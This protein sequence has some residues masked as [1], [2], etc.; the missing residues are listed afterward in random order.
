MKISVRVLLMGIVAV[1][2]T[3]MS[4]VGIQGA[5]GMQA[6]R[7]ALGRIY[8][9][10]FLPT[11]YISQADAALVTWNREMLKY[12]TASPGEMHQVQVDSVAR[13]REIIHDKLERLSALSN[14]DSEEE[15][16][17]KAL[18]QELV[19]LSASWDQVVRLRE[20]GQDARAKAFLWTTITP[21]IDLMSSEVTRFVA[22]QEKQLRQV[23]AQAT[24]IFRGTLVR[25]LLVVVAAIFLSLV[26]NLSLSMRM[27]ES[28][29]RL[30][31][32]AEQ[33]GNG[34]LQYRVEAHGIEETAQLAAVFNQ[35]TEKLFASEKALRDA[36]SELERRVEER[37]KELAHRNDELRKEIEERKRVQQAL[38]DS[39]EKL[40][41]FAFSVMH[42]LKSPAVGIHGMAMLLLKHYG[43]LLDE[44][45]R[46]Y[47]ELLASSSKNIGVFVEEL[48][49][50]IS[51][52]ETPLTVE[53]IHLG[54]LAGSLRQEFSTVLSERN[55][56]WHDENFEADILADR[57]SVTRVLSNFVENAIKYG[58][59]QLS[60]ITL[61]YRRSGDD[62]IMSVADN[63]VGIKDEDCERIF[64][65]FHRSEAS[66]GIPGSGLGL[67]IVREIA[68]RHGG[69]AWAEPGPKGGAVFHFSIPARPSGR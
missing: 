54:E 11:F 16:L 33:I 3:A 67:A 7:D 65:L 38:A 17:L 46:N 55:I 40:K 26:T 66:K 20:L 12:V 21:Q 5:F 56:T 34:N 51:S 28:F 30:M 35:M 10:Q 61:E 4:I 59:E 37:T 23:E 22:I 42:D 64:D 6:I 69:R 63:G 25:M 8:T 24:E 47:C 19:K 45:G 1:S 2:L 44:R 62:H 31:H 36:N 32:G 49:T 29:K 39:T 52:R 15:E 18:Q 68:A 60:E 27:V 14:L 13:Q 9:G 48:N 58:G 57:L 50:Y 43:H 53:E 41:I